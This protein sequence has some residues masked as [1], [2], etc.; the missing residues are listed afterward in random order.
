MRLFQNFSFRTGSNDKTLTLQLVNLFD[1]F[2]VKK[3]CWSSLAQA[4]GV[5]WF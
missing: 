1:F 3:F 2:V 5:C 4:D